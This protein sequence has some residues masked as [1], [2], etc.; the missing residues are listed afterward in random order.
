MR[1][2]LQYVYAS[3]EKFVGNSRLIKNMQNALVVIKQPN[4]V[5]ICR[6]D[7]GYSLNYIETPEVVR[8][9]TFVCSAYKLTCCYYSNTCK[10]YYNY[11]IRYGGR[12]YT[13]CIGMHRRILIPYRASPNDIDQQICAIDTNIDIPVHVHSHIIKYK[14]HEWM[15]YSLIGCGDILKFLD[16]FGDDGAIKVDYKNI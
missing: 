7:Y 12:L 4:T 10:N 2:G 11:T 15:V 8:R 6:S 3:Y 14:V 13:T 16:K 1:R 5:C 9:V